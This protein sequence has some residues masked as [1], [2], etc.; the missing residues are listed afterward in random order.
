MQRTMSPKKLARVLQPAA[1]AEA[2][3]TAQADHAPQLRL[4]AGLHLRTRHLQSLRFLR[5][6][7]RLP[8]LCTPC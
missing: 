4:A 6:T 2:L 3:C 1:T 5:L 7:R 8:A